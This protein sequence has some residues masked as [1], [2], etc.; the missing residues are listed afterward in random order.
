MTF[1]NSGLLPPGGSEDVQAGLLPRVR[2]Y[3]RFRIETSAVH[4]VRKPRSL[5]LTRARP[6]IGRPGLRRASMLTFLA[7]SMVAWV[8]IKDTNE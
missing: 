2:Q 1:K 4:I 8:M 7:W 3:E 5:L 6:T